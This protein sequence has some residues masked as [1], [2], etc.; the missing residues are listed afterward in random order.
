MRLFIALNFNELKDYFAEL[1]KQ[2]PKEDVKLTLPK[3]FHLTLKF[4]GEVGDSKIDEIKKLLSEIKLKPFDAKITTIGFFTEQ[5]IRTIWIKAE[6]KEIIELQ[7]QI[8]EK[9]I[10]LFKKEKDFE[11]HITLARVKFVKDKNA[12]I[13]QTKKIKTTEKTVKIKDFEL[14][15]SVLTPEGPVYEVLSILK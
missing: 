9:L 5:F 2:I 4:L 3:D 1:Q 11:P 13:E 7:K 6:A 14:V 10:S 8:D 15:K 12:V